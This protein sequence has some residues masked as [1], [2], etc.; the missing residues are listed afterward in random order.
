MVPNV[1]LRK[2]AL[3]LGLRYKFSGEARFVAARLGLF[4]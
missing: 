3:D 1:G 4:F 2:G